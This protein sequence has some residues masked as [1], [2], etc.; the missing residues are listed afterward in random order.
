MS[1]N[2]LVFRFLV[3]FVLLLVLLWVLVYTGLVSCDFLPGGCEVYY[4]VVKGRAPKVLIAYSDYGL[5]D[6]NKLEEL[7]SDRDFLGSKVSSI[8]ISLLTY[9][10]ISNYDLIIVERAKKICSD[11]LRLF[12]YY[13]SIGGRLVWTGDAGTEL[14]ENDRLLLE[15]QRIE[16]GKEFPLGPWAREDFGRQL[17][18]DETLGLDYVGNYC[19]FN[20]CSKNSFSGYL[21]VLDSEHKLVYGLSPT[22]EFKGD[23]ALVRSKKSSNV[24]IVAVI[25]NLSDVLVSSD[26][27]PWIEKGKKYDVGKKL[28]LIVTNGVGE[29]V[30]YYAAPIESFYYNGDLR[31]KALI[32]QLYYGMLYK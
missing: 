2:N 28:P 7:L 21:E 20:D 15:N 31:Y 32:E 25:D 12:Q 8:D 26:N 4:Q 22:L 27:K 23:Y 5:G 30:A 9:G 16:G 14:C 1:S 18:F 24:K 13:L 19:E 6:P 17:S 10:T 3:L 29:R 11:K